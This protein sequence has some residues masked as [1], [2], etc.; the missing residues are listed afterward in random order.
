MTKFLL[1]LIWNGGFGG[2]FGE[3]AA[4]RKLDGGRVEV[5]TVFICLHECW[6]YM[7]DLG[8]ELMLGPILQCK[9]PSWVTAKKPKVE[10]SLV[11]MLL[12]AD[13]L[14]L[15]SWIT[16]YTFIN[17]RITLYACEVQTCTRHWCLISCICFRT[18]R[19]PRHCSVVLFGLFFLRQKC[20]PKRHLGN[21]VS[22][23]TS[24]LRWSCL[25]IFLTLAPE[26]AKWPFLQLSD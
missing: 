17:H 8:V 10:C 16:T 24:L 23:S 26:V 9:C 22:V 25:A 18:S 4:V 11:W 7:W 13:L 3:R 1:N 20:K 12:Y 5:C 19:K 14:L 15:T 6:I 2:T 21:M